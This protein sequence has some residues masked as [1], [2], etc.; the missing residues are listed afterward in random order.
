MLINTHKLKLALAQSNPTLSLLSYGSASLLLLR[1]DRYTASE[2]LRSG[3]GR[4]SRLVGLEDHQWLEW[5]WILSRVYGVVWMTAYLAHGNAWELGRWCWWV[6]RTSAL[7]DCNTVNSCRSHCLEWAQPMTAR[8]TKA[9][10]TEW[11][12]SPNRKTDDTLTDG[13]H[14]S[15][16]GAAEISRYYFLLLPTPPAHVCVCQITNSKCMWEFWVDALPGR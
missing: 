15:V 11:P 7:A 6:W 4:G 16:R 2:D 3:C 10:A 1:L 9:W 12:T 13:Q 8:E 14:V 5:V